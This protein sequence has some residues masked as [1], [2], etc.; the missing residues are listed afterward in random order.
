M[1]KGAIAKVSEATCIYVR[2]ISHYSICRYGVESKKN[3]KVIH[4]HRTRLETRYICI[5]VTVCYMHLVYYNL[6]PGWWS[7]VRISTSF[8]SAGCYDMHAEEPHRK[9]VTLSSLFWVFYLTIWSAPQLNIA[10]TIHCPPS[11]NIVSLF[12]SQAQWEGDTCSY[13]IQNVLLFTHTNNVPCSDTISCIP[14][15]H[16]CTQLGLSQLCWA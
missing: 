5:N 2:V 13:R 3:T 16:T 4:Q 14:E 10:P 6:V 8:P 12:I 11:H 9:R 7:L 15:W 1:N